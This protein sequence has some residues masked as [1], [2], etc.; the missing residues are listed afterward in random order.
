M[1][2]R[3]KQAYQRHRLE[4]ERITR[5]LKRLTGKR[6]IDLLCNDASPP[7]IAIAIAELSIQRRMKGGQ[8]MR[9]LEAHALLPRPHLRQVPPTPPPTPRAS[10]IPVSRKRPPRKAS[11]HAA[12]STPD[13]FVVGHQLPMHAP[14]QSRRIPLPRQPVDDYIYFY[15]GQYPD[16][17]YWHPQGMLFQPQQPHQPHQILVK[18]E[19]P[20]RVVDERFIAELVDELILETQESKG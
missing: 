12:K 13:L 9:S 16:M 1:E 20:P 14:P 4:R 18:G 19:E 7:P 5:R 6:S 15:P 8:Q 2:D 17:I 11:R 3:L 10:P